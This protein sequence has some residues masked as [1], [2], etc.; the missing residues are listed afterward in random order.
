VTGESER[1]QLA[2]RKGGNLDHLGTRARQGAVAHLSQIRDSNHA[3]RLL[4]P[5]VVDAQQ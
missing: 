5:D 2:G 3:W 1:R 4:F